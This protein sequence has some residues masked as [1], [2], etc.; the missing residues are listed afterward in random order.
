ML[1]CV[2]INFSEPWSPEGHKLFQYLA[3]SRQHAHVNAHK[4]VDVRQRYEHVVCVCARVCLLWIVDETEVDWGVQG[5]L[6]IVPPAVLDRH[7]SLVL[8]EVKVVDVP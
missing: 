1:L 8:Q 2:Q 5:D 7:H 6:E 4:H 3:L